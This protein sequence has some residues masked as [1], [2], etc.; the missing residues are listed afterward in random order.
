M[1]LQDF[2][3]RETGSNYIFLI[4]TALLAVFFLPIFLNHRYAE[5]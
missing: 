4:M 2:S 3:G 5:I 1:L